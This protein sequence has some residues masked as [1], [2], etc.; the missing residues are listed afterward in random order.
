MDEILVHISAPTTRQNDDLYRSLADAYVNFEPHR[1]ITAE[2]SEDRNDRETHTG[3]ETKATPA[4]VFGN[5]TNDPLG[6]HISNASRDSYGSFPSDMSSDNHAKAFDRSGLQQS[7]GE[8]ADTGS[9]LPISRLGQ[10]ERIQA[11]WRNRWEPRPSGSG[12]RR[13]R[14]SSFVASTNLDT[15]FIEDSQLAARLIESQL[16]QQGS[17]TSEDTSEDDSA[18]EPHPELLRPS[19]P[20]KQ[21]P[22]SQSSTSSRG[23]GEEPY[24]NTELA[25]MLQSTQANTS[26]A[27]S[28]IHESIGDLSAL[29]D[30]LDFSKLP[31]EVIP[32]APKV[33][34]ESPGTL[35]SQIT[36]HLEAIQTQNP[37]RFKPSKI[38]RILELDER[39]Y[40][41][42]ESAAWP[43]SIQ[44]E[45]WSSLC[46]YVN[47]GRFGW[48]VTLYRDPPN[49]H[50]MGAQVANGLGLVRLYCWGEIVEHIWLSLWLCSKG[51]VA[52]SGLKW[53][54]AE[55]NV[56][57]RVP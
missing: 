56:V 5:S 29:A 43:L 52:G 26:S 37:M 19:I 48:G 2:V 20:G 13:S 35:P 44:Y 38:S 54:D 30:C 4:P 6:M 49:T 23:A 53:F 16:Y 17:A 21:P 50:T 46:K 47:G 9:L 51:K 3:L 25:S 31:C 24:T 18:E 32:P 39:G 41:L 33:S 57:V 15:T 45:F 22:L 36:T 8:V 14:I 42:I 55:D 34:I 11:N 1:R 40:W 12:E 10:L 27:T 28:Y 7:F